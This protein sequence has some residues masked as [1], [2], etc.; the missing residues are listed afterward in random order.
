MWDGFWGG[1]GAAV[2]GLFLLWWAY[3]S[4]KS[5]AWRD[6]KRTVE[7]GTAEQ[8]EALAKAKFHKRPREWGQ[9]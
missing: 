9:P 6:V 8:F 3:E 7:M 5:A 1:V 4:G 2:I